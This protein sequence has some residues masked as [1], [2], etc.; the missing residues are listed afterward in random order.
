MQELCSKININM[1]NAT[2][3]C[4]VIDE[5]YAL[6]TAKGRFGGAQENAI[7]EMQSYVNNS[8]HVKF[9]PGKHMSR[10]Q[11]RYSLHSRF[12]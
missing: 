11:L 2:D 1:H 12:F 7:F 4:H 10:L 9:E 8:Q 3:A 6:E 5:A